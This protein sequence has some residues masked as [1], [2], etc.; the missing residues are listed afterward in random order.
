VATPELHWTALVVGQVPASTAWQ[1]LRPASSS[2]THSPAPKLVQLTPKSS[3]PPSGSQ[4]CSPPAS[5]HQLP[6]VVHAVG[7]PLQAALSPEE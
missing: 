6:A 4:S 1:A 2:V 3:S 7:D 5:S